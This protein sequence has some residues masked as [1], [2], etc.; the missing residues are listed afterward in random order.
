MSKKEYKVHDEELH[1]DRRLIH[2]VKKAGIHTYHPKGRWNGYGYE[3]LPLVAR[4]TSLSEMRKFNKI[5]R[6]L[7]KEPPPKVLTEEEKMEAWA[8]SLVRKL[9]DTEYAIDY[10]EAKDIAVEKL[11]YQTDRIYNLMERQVTERFSKKREKLINKLERENPL[12]RITDTGHAIAIVE[13]SER[14]NNTDYEEYLEEYH[15][16]EEEGEVVKGYAKEYA[17][18]AIHMSCEERMQLIEEYRIKW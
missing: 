8:K 17:R 1:S 3:Q 16:F 2:R 10:E 14:H 4:I 9:K 15:E 7:A 18:R 6:E 13:A 5:K 12:R 11:N